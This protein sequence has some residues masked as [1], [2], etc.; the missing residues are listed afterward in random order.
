MRHQAI[1]SSAPQEAWPRPHPYIRGGRGKLD[2]VRPAGQVQEG[3]DTGGVVEHGKDGAAEDGDLVAGLQIGYA[4]GGFAGGGVV[5]TV[6]V[7]M[8]RGTYLRRGGPP[9]ADRRWPDENRPLLN[10]RSAMIFLLA[11]LV[12]L[13]AGLLAHLAANPWPVAIT[14]QRGHDRRG[15]P[16]LRPD[17]RIGRCHSGAPHRATRT[18]QHPGSREKTGRCAPTVPHLTKLLHPSPRGRNGGAGGFGQPVPGPAARDCL[19]RRRSPSRR[20]L[21]Y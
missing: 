20:P 4:D 12:G 2:C 1:S 6:G 18:A 16:I 13:G 9:A 8:H 3:G 21:R 19:F 14:G 5:G 10:Q 17:H 11:A 7:V 15:R